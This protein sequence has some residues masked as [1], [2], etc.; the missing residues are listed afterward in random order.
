MDPVLYQHLFFQTIILYTIPLTVESS[1][2]CFVTFNTLY[3]NRFPNAKAPSKFFLEWLV[4][5]AEGDCSFTVNSRKTAVFVIT[6]STVDIQI[7]QYIQQTLVVLSS[8][9]QQLV[10]L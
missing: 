8:K 3:A 4:G 9:D 6:Q 2:F 1:N 7:L 5:F 10:V